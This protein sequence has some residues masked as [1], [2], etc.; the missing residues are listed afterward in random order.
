M[1]VIIVTN[2]KGVDAAPAESYY[3]S[4]GEFPEALDIIKKSI[5]YGYHSVCSTTNLDKESLMY[6]FQAMT[7]YGAKVIV[8]DFLKN[9]IK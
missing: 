1:K 8:S 2:R 5:L 6:L 9:Q 4:F 7:A 3:F